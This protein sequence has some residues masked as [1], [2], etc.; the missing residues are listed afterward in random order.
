MVCK[1]PV[2]I[3]RVHLKYCI[4][5]KSGHATTRKHQGIANL[6]VHIIQEISSI[7]ETLNVEEHVEMRN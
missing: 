1:S 3:R 2:D 5:L 4:S 7:T 6:I